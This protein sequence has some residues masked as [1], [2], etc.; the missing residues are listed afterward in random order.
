MA[1][2]ITV[3]TTLACTNGDVIL[4]KVGGGSYTL[5]QNNP[6]IAA[7]N[8]SCVA[9]AGGSAI[10]LTGITTKGFTY[11]KNPD[12]SI[13]ISIGHWDGSTLHVFATLKP[14]ETFEGRIDN[15]VSLRAISASGTPKLV[16]YMLE[17]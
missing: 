11:L 9:T 8:H 16:G 17:D 13:N 5:T 4:P 1:N 10:A 14:G 7:I 6:G 3:Q 15:A 2:E 12:S